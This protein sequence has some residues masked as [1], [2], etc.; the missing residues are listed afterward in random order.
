MRVL[1]QLLFFVFLFFSLTMSLII[2]SSVFL[3]DE[4]VMTFSLASEMKMIRSGRVLAADLENVEARVPILIYHHIRDFSESDSLEA[5]TF[6]VTPEN[7]EAQLKYLQENN[8]T[9]IS[10]KDLVDYLAGHFIMPEQPVIISF[11]D[12]LSNQ[13]AN[14]LPLLEKYNFVATFF[15]F[16][17]PIGRSKNYLT[18]EQ[19]KELDELGMEI[20]SHGK[21]HL[22]FNRLN[23]DNRLVEEVFD[24]KK[25]I[26]EKLGKGIS[27]IAYPFGSYDQK[28]MAVVE[29]A[30]YKSA[31]DIINGNIHTPKDLYRLRGYFVT[32]NLS[33]F[34]RIVGQ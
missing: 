10:F 7:F 34:T 30:G 26:E 16:T 9:P 2:V 17:N 29:E 33:R 6:I 14:A 1:N 31:R 25:I 20:G 23:G 12:G 11:D 3:L 22:F 24:S 18:W 4:E 32:N 21:Y 28:V 5:E 27:T 15:I 19:V 8:F 13:Y